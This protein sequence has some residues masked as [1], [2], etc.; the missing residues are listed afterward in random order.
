MP[1]LVL[2]RVR[3]VP[4]CARTQEDHYQMTLACRPLLL[5]AL[6]LTSLSAH[7]GDADNWALT[8]DG[9]FRSD[10]RTWARD[11]PGQDLQAFRGRVELPYSQLEVLAVLA[12]IDNFPKWIFQCDGARHLTDVGDDIVYIHI[13]GIWPVDDRDVVT[14]TR[15][16][17]NPQTGTIS[18]HSSADNGLYPVQKKTVRMPEF[19]NLFTL[20]PRHDGWT[21]ITFETFANPGGAI[22]AWLANLVATRAPYETLRDMKKR[23]KKKRYHISD[24]QQLPFTLPGLDT[25]NISSRNPR[26][27]S[28]AHVAF[29]EH[30]AGQVA[31]IGDRC[32]WPVDRLSLPRAAADRQSRH[33]RSG[34]SFP[35]ASTADPGSV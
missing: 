22:P 33:N 17:Q 2:R 21:R 13:K 26:A 27:Y 34:R 15:I 20:E 30:I 6:L 31:A 23:L 10:I 7:A 9:T 35:D 18:I 1:I 5:I 29:F 14:R 11:I 24:R 19:E 25:M 16:S 3:G 8:R 4:S 28:D 32:P 12:D